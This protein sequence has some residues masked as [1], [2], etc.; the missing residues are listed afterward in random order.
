VAA[1]VIVVMGVLLVIADIVNP[2]KLFN[3]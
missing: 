1:S 3:G 2:I